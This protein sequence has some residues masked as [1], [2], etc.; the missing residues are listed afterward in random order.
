[1]NV[2]ELDEAQLVRIPVEALRSHFQ[3]ADE[4]QSDSQT[5]PPDSYAVTTWLKGVDLRHA[6]LVRPRDSIDGLRR[7]L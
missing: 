3:A 7:L 1:M 4:D 2:E 6:A 5:P